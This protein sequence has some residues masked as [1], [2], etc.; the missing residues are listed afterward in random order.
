MAADVYDQKVK[1]V[2]V[3]NC[4]KTVFCATIGEKLIVVPECTKT[5][6]HTEIRCS[7]ICKND[8]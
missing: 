8:V 4:R 5:A 3:N 1:S 6:L 7:E 2:M